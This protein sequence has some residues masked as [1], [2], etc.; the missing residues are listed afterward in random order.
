MIERPFRT[1][2][3]LLPADFARRVVARAESIQRRRRIGRRAA[4]AVAACAILFATAFLRPSPQGAPAVTQQSLASS[5]SWM[6]VAEG[7][8][9]EADSSETQ[10]ARPIALFFP[11]AT[12]LTNFDSAY[13][14]RGW[15]SYDSWGIPIPSERVK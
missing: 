9:G 7:S 6:A 15:H 2:E 5:S 4:A 8:I 3:N 12:S 14:E 13:G 11:D 10:T 1:S